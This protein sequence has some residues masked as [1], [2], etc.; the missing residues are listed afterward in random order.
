MR[1]ICSN[2]GHLQYEIGESGGCAHTFW[3]W[4]II[5]TLLIS[6]FYWL[7]FIVL[8]FEILF[9]ILTGGKSN[10]CKKCKAKDCVIPVNTPRG[11]KL[12]DE[13]Y[14]YEEVTE[15]RK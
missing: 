5:V 10:C 1:Y 11:K 6:L 12:F 9:F 7:G 14:E 2:C 8:A 15:E 4:C 3:G 13:Y